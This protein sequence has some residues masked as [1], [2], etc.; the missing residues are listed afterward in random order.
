MT[1]PFTTCEEML[2]FD[3]GNNAPLWKLA[4]RY[5]ME[6]GDLTEAAVM[7]RMRDIVRVLRRSIAKHLRHSMRGQG[8]GQ[9]SNQ[10]QQASNGG[11]C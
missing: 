7:E 10:F 11:A 6:R 2:R 9:Q 1:V 5:E 4:A 3:A 8:A